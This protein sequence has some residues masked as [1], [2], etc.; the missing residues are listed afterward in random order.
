MFWLVGGGGD[1]ERWVLV[2]WQLLLNGLYY[3]SFKIAEEC[4]KFFKSQIIRAASWDMER[5]D[6]RLG[7]SFHEKPARWLLLNNNRGTHVEHHFVHVGYFQSWKVDNIFKWQSFNTNPSRADSVRGASR[8][9]VSSIISVHL[10]SI[11][12]NAL[13][14]AGFS[15]FP[16]LCFL[17]NWFPGRYV[18]YKV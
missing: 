11:N 1:S 14:F 15:L 16:V 18:G 5:A 17:L 2:K 7:L 3:Y 13:S 12:L 9:M 6:R 10:L 8:L 4:P